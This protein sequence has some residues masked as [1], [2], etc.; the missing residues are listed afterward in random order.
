[1]HRGIFENPPPAL[2]IR[3]TQLISGRLV[4]LFGIG[5]SSSI[6]VVKS[7]HNCNSRAGVHLLDVKRHR[8]RCSR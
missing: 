5:I 4:M 2:I 3:F 6:S 1:M 8:G 7:P